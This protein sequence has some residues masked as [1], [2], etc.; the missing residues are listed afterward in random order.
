MLGDYDIRECGGDCIGLEKPVLV[1]LFGSPLRQE[2]EKCDVFSWRPRGMGRLVFPAS[3]ENPRILYTTT[4]NGM[5]DAPNFSIHTCESHYTSNTPPIRLICKPLP[6]FHLSHTIHPSIPV[7]NMPS[8]IFAEV[9]TAPPDPILSLTQL[10]RSDPHPQKVNLGVGA[11][12][13]SDGNPYILPVVRAVELQIA[14][15]PSTNHEY[16]PQDGLS[17]FCR[18]SAEL[19]LGRDSRALHEDR[20]VTVQALS[21][22]GALRIGFTFIRLFLGHRQVY[23]PRQTWSN[24]RNVV[25]QSGLADV[26]DYT[27]LDLAS[28]SVDAE[29]LLQDIGRMERGSVMLLHGCAHNPTG[30]DPSRA[31]WRAILAAVK[32]RGVVPFFDNAYQGFASGNLATDAW[33]TRLFVDAGIDCFVAQSYAKNMGLYG[34]RVGALNVICAEGGKID[35]IRSQLKAIVRAM[36]SSPPLHGAR[37]AA[38]ILGDE[39]LFQEWEAELVKMSGRIKEMRVGLRDELVRIEAPGNWEHIMSQIGMFSFTG[40]TRQQVDFIREKYHIYMTRNG[41]ISM[42]GLTAD[43]IEYVAGAIKDAVVSVVK[44]D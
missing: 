10:F 39:G 9:P 44:Q 2:R 6:P 15:D 25:P 43:T 37:V 22:T 4:S 21:G 24:H 33:A 11:Y 3:N 34:E 18:L 14:S 5:R 40:L 7:T 16:L 13:T 29:G 27:Y 26:K 20:V 30:A 32:E 41:R 8:T 17:T 23:V 42:A 38:R 31:L 28:G 1:R 36:Y 12:R 19:I 35:A